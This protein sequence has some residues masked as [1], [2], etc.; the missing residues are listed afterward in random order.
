[1]VQFKYNDQLVAD[2]HHI[3]IPGKMFH[4]HELT[5][6]EYRQLIGESKKINLINLTTILASY[7][8]RRKDFTI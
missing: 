3:L 4:V 6:Y 1:M 5:G 8:D 2:P 7:V